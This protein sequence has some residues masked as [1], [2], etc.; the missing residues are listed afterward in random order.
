MASYSVACAPCQSEVTQILCYVAKE[1]KVSCMDKFCQPSQRA[2]KDSS[3]GVGGR[4]M[5]SKASAGVLK[6]QCF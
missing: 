4:G 1:R 2:L 3:V 5:R 6:S